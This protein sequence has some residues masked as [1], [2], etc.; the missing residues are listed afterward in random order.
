MTAA[1]K[2]INDCVSP[3]NEG[4]RQRLRALSN[5]RAGIAPLT[6]N[7]ALDEYIAQLK[8]L[9]PEMFHTANTLKHRVFFD[10]PRSL[11]IPFARCVRSWAQSPLQQG[12]K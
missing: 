2:L 1:E 7:A 3:F 12:N 5:V 4:Q 8:A 11:L 10:E 9:Y 6:S